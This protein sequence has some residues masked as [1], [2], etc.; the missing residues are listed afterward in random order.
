MT[1]RKRYPKNPLRN[2]TQKKLRDVF[3]DLEVVDAPELLQMFPND[4]DFAKAEPLNP[5]NCGFYHCAARSI[6][7]TSALVFAT[8][9]F[10]DHVGKDGK[11]RIYRYKNSRPTQ[12]TIHRFDAKKKVDVSKAFIFLPPAESYTLDYQRAKGRRL[13]KDPRSKS[14]LQEWMARDRLRQAEGD[15]E[16]WQ[17]RAERQSSSHQTASTL[18]TEKQVAR[19]KKKV[20]ELRSDYDDKHARAKEVR[21]RPYRAKRTEGHATHNLRIRNGTGFMSR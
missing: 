7:A 1:D 6:G 20:R 19:L 13:R 5:H 18:A 2:P 14:I 10:F 15:L 4:E 9:S 3:G 8:T 21:M 17:T 12:R 16:R 11:R